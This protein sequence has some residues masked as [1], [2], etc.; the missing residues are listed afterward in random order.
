MRRVKQVGGQVFALTP[1]ACLRPELPERL[2]GLGYAQEVKN[3]EMLSELF[4][5]RK[6][7]VHPESIGEAT[8]LLSDSDFTGEGV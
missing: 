3:I 4:D 6:T 5:I 8:E 1:G 7:K 2:I